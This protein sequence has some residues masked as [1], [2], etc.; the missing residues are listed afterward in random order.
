METQISLEEYLNN[1]ELNFGDLFISAILDD[2]LP[3]S[4][5]M[6]EL[7]TFCVEEC[8]MYMLE[9]RAAENGTLIDTELVYQ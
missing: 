7:E 4:Y 2:T 6:S 8:A 9:Q 1:P 5:I 3:D